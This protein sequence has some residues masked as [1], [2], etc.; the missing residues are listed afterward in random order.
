MKLGIGFGP[1]VGDSSA[2]FAPGLDFWEDT[3]CGKEHVARV[4]VARVFLSR[5]G[6]TQRVAAVRH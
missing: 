3:F 6:T 1:L 2:T 5:R 4:Y